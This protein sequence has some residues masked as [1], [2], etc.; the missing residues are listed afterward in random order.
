MVLPTLPSFLELKKVNF[1][2]DYLRQKSN[3]EFDRM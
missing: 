1:N 2:Q 3:N